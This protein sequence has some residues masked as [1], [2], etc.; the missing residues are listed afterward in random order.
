MPEP[1]KWDIFFQ[2]LFHFLNNLK[3][4]DFP[5]K[6]IKNARLATLNSDKFPG[7]KKFPQNTK[8]SL[9][10]IFRATCNR[11]DWSFA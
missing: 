4:V 3:N 7:G 1:R 6:G 10:H 9:Y 11:A 8:A 5:D 2:V